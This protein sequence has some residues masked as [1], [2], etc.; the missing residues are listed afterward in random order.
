[1]TY[2]TVQSAVRRNNRPNK[3]CEDFLVC[4]ETAF[5]VADGVTQ[6][7]DEYVEG[8]TTSH[9][10]EVARLTAETIAAALETAENP[11]AAARGAVQ[12]AIAAAAE[13]NAAHPGPFPAAAVFVSGAIRAGTLHFAYLGDSLITLIREG[14]RIRLSEQQTSHL[15]VYGSTKGLNITKRE[16]YDT[17]TNNAAHP[18]GYGIVDGEDRALAFLRAARVALQSGDRVI[19]SS[20]GIDKYL[21]FAPVE[22]LASLPPEALLDRSK[23]YDK[24]PYNPYADDKAVITIDVE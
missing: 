6:N 14:V 9:A 2:Y 16:L 23:A 7:H 11:T 10:G 17:I 22:E 21:S 8:M 18:L 20:D 5:V 15:R 13:Y 1:M 24:P 3:P 4:G 12:A 19:L